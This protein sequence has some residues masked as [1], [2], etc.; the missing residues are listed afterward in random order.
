MIKKLTY[1][2][3]TF[4]LFVACDRSKDTSSLY[5]EDDYKDVVLGEDLIRIGMPDKLDYLINN[6]VISDEMIGLLASEDKSLFD[7]SLLNAS[8]NVKFY[9]TT[10]NKAVNMGVYGAELNYLIHFGQTQYSM[11]YMV[12]SKQLADQIGVAMA[13]DQQA[14]EEY[15]TNAENRDSLISI[16]FGVYDNARRMLKNEEQF[17]LSSLVI[18]GSW[19]ENMYLT[20]EMFSRTKSTALKSKLVTNILE[21]K[22]YMEKILEAIKLLD[23]GDNVFVTEIIKDLQTIDSIYV[24]F[25]DRLLSEEDVKTLN[26]AISKVRNNVITVN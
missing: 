21:Q 9:T 2:L 17:M 8:E 18:V 15:Q 4:L 22:V 7:K 10:K 13:F 20:T 3:L 23:E 16:I 26:E 25:G 1:C 5:N 11:K 6:L 19:I 14:V 24:D 12:A